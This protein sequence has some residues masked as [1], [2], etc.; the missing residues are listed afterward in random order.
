MN[1]ERLLFCNYWKKE[2]FQKKGLDF[3]CAA[4]TVP[5]LV[6]KSVC[7]LRQLVVSCID[8]S[9]YIHI[10]SMYAVLPPLALSVHITPFN[11]SFRTNYL[12]TNTF[13]YLGTHWCSLFCGLHIWS[14]HWG[15]LLIICKDG[16]RWAGWFLSLSI[17]GTLLLPYI[18]S[19]VF[20]VGSIS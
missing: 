8:N 5:N 3:L 20:I 2:Y 6:V 7:F 10:I 12:V 1:R 18:G 13:I 17:P 19:S 11:L 4:W 9:N 16:C 14:S 15:L